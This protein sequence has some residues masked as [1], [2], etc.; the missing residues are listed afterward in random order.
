MKYYTNLFTLA[1]PT[2][3]AEILDVVQPNV[4]VEMNNMLASEFQGIEVS[5]A[6]KQMYP[7]KA[8]GPNGMPTLFYQH[9][10]QPV[11]ECVIKMVLD[12]LNHGKVSLKFNE[13]HIF[14]IPKAKNPIKVAE[15]HPISLCNVVYKLA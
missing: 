4:S 11:G 12:F 14:L 13:T 2:D 6:L 5:Q 7:T 15:Y 1:H 8:P 3:F 10:W 9:F